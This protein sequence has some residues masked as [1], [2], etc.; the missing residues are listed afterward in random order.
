M[1]MLMSYCEGDWSVRMAASDDIS[2]PDSAVDRAENTTDARPASGGEQSEADVKRVRAIH[3][4]ARRMDKLLLR[5]AQA[6]RRPEGGDSHD[7]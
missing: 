1:A 7:R 3:D 5:W 6:R 4:L 2:H